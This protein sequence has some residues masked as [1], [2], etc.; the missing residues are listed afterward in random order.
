MMYGCDTGGTYGSIR[1]EMLTT[2]QRGAMAEN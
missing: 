1:V 2:E